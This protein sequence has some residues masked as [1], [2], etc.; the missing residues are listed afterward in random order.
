VAAVRSA[1]GDDVDLMID[2]N[3]RWDT[4]T[5]LTWAHR[6]ED[7][8]I[9]WLEE[10][11]DPDDVG[12]P[13]AP[14]RRDE[15]PHRAGRARLLAHDVPRLHRARI[16]GYVQA[17]CTRLGGVTEWLAVA[18]I[19]LA[20]HVPVVP[21]HADMMRVHQHLGAGHAACPMIECIPGCRRSSPR[22]STSATASSTCPT[23]GR[24]DHLRRGKFMSSASPETLVSVEHM[25]R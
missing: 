6:F 8:D 23:S 7:F 4:T 15:D 19:A 9:R 17:D 10:P 2:V 20:H 13:R 5:A 22:R 14:G 16:I 18:E 1:L 21:H 12:G 25:E 3:Q 11:L 24:L